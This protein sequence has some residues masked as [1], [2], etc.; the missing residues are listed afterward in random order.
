MSDDSEPESE[1]KRSSSRGTKTKDKPPQIRVELVSDSEEKKTTEKLNESRRKS[2]Y[3]SLV[4]I[5]TGRQI[6]V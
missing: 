5:K 2:R 3:V 4:L 6:H 1:L